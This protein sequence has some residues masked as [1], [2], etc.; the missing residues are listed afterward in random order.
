[1]RILLAAL[2]LVSTALL[3]Q[4]YPTPGPNRDPNP[5]ST[6][7]MSYQGCIIRSNGGVMLTDASNRDYKLV[8]SA[9]KLD[10]YVGQE[11]RITA[12]LM[13]P[14]DPSSDEKSVSGEAPQNQPKTLDVQDI[15]KLA[16]KCSSPK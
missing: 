10:S 2:V 14:N 3:A 9:R 5:Q 12:T 7:P 13:N 6:R 4:E 1:M 11:V 16:D 15:A 8:S